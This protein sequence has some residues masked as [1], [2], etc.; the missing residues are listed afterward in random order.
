MLYEIQYDVMSIIAICFLLSVYVLRRN[1]KTKANTILLLLIICDLLGAVFDI[2]SCY[3]ITYPERYSMWQNYI[4]TQGYIFFY[5]M[6]GVLFFAYIDS[7][8]KIKV[9]W[10]PVK[11]IIA[12]IVLLESF[13]IFSS[14]LTHVISYFDA[15]L[16]YHHGPFMALLYVIAATLLASASVMFVIERRKFNVY[17]VVAICSFVAAVFVGVLVQM[18]FPYILV[19]QFACTL[20]LFFIYT[21]L[22]N[23]VYYTYR[24]TRCYNR[25][26]FLETM[27]RKLHGNDAVHVLAFGIKDYD[28]LRD[29]LNLRELERLSSKIAEFLRSRLRESA[30]CIADDKFVILMNHTDEETS[31]RKMLEDYFSQA[32]DLVDTS[33]LVAIRMVAIHNLDKQLKMDVIENGITYLLE[34]SDVAMKKSEDFTD[35][36]KQMRRRKDVSHA[37][38]AAIENDLFEVFYQPIRNVHTGSFTSVEALIRLQDPKLGFISPEE[39]I[40]IAESEGMILKIGEMVFEKVCQFI[41]ES[42]LIEAL[43]VHYIEI[44]LSPIQ[45]FQADLVERFTDIMN[46]YQVQPGWINLEIT[47]T[48][49][50]EENNQMVQNMNA[51]HQLGTTFSLD[52]YGSGFA[53]IDYLFK[54]PV[55]IVKIDKGILWQAMKDPNAKIVLI[56]TLQMLK[57]LKKRVVVEGVENEEMVQLL[58]QNGCDYMQGYYYSK[59]IPAKEYLAFL[60]Q[61]FKND[62]DELIQSKEDN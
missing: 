58:E 8:T 59:P 57:N 30:F 7:K 34:H 26:A 50:F 40:P 17:Q 19:G 3:A 44:N 5:N 13:W 27:K 43:G 31:I 9:L 53:S 37:V 21:S 32:I 41:L 16:E 28:Y 39:F 38:S 51:F 22:E 42:H 12:L 61:H 4:M 33:V 56:S 62:K 52:D 20:V 10:K 47:E 23:P 60:S 45:C 1:Y 54:L 15:N 11:M 18:L 25:E 24:G 29:G 55:D 6:M 35:V 14:P 36:V 48:A 49:S 2:A 46:K